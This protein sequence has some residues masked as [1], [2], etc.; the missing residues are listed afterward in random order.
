MLTAGQS[1]TTAK[2]AVD[3]RK[4]IQVLTEELSVAEEKLE[5]T[6]REKDSAESKAFN[7][8]ASASKPSG[9][10]WTQLRAP[11]CMFRRELPRYVNN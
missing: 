11:R 2:D 10:D 5:T 4:Q 1:E 8:R 6:K 3:V 7:L 9:P